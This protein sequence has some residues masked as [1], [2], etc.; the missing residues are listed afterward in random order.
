MRSQ[1][2]RNVCATVGGSSRAAPFE[3]NGDTLLPRGRNRFMQDGYRTIDNGAGQCRFPVASAIGRPTQVS[4]TV[5]STGVMLVFRF[6]KTAD[7]ERMGRSAAIDSKPDSSI[8]RRV[9]DSIG[10]ISSS[11]IR[12]ACSRDANLYRILMPA[13]SM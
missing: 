6:D 3:Y 9:G 5:S 7:Q 4:L 12:K 1:A 8:S 13:L 11:T 2:F 10:T